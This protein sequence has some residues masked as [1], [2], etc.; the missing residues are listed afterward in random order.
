MFAFV[1][2]IIG[3]CIGIILF[4]LSLE[5]YFASAFAELYIICPVQFL[6]V[7]NSVNA[8]MYVFGAVVE[9]Y[10]FG[11]I[12]DI[13]GYQWSMFMMMIV[14]FIALII[15]VIKHRLQ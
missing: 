1:D 12:A 7:A 5:W 15:S 13:V 11:H 3:L 14:A 9:T 2:D 4:I 10:L 6:S 8:V